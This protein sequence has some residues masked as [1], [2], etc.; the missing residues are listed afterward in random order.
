MPYLYPI[1]HW[2]TLSPEEINQ[3]RTG[4]KSGDSEQQTALA[5]CY[6]HGKG[7][8]KS[9]PQALKWFSKAAKNGYEEA[10]DCLGDMYLLGYG[11]TA[12]LAKS[13]KWYVRAAEQGGVERQ[14]RLGK[15][16]ATGG[17]L[18]GVPKDYFKAAMWF[19]RAADQGDVESQRFLGELCHKGE[20]TPPTYTEMF[21]NHVLTRGYLFGMGD[22]ILHGMGAYHPF[23]KNFSEA[24]K[25][26]TKAAEQGDPKAQFGLGEMYNAGEGV[27]QDDVQAYAW[28]NIA[29][30]SGDKNA[31]R[32]YN[33]LKRR[34]TP[35][36]IAKAQE[37]SSEIW[38]R[39]RCHK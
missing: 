35:E 14:S 34:M 23:P 32:S 13:E 11:V 31:K 1:L 9:Y 21:L 36:Q 37:L 26:Y 29:G 24:V 25:W 6:Y 2:P 16:Y 7:V 28:L 10:Q 19:L 22:K 15:K 5:R 17:I 3:A 38:G 20:I 33:R 30:T 4:A 27:L 18:T 39:I 8:P 12:D